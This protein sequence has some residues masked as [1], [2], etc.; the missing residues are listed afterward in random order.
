MNK[1]ISIFALSFLLA[2]CSVYKMDVQQG[3][4]ISNETVG[5]LR[6]GMSKSE[7]ASL[8]GNPLLQD[9]FR[10]NRWDY[11]YYTGRGRTSSK[12]QGLTLFFVN[13][14]LVQIKQ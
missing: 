11:I 1:I 13:E 9:N 12:Q 14:Q 2:S 7:V 8:L 4:S 10:G 5:Q 3:N 6:K